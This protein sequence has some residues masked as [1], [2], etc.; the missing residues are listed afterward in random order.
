[1]LKKVI[2]IAVFFGFSGFLPVATYATETLQNSNV[3]NSAWNAVETQFLYGLAERSLS[4]QE[5]NQQWVVYSMSLGLIAASYALETR[6]PVINSLQEIE[7]VRPNPTDEP[8]CKRLYDS[9]G[10]E[11]LNKDKPNLL[12]QDKANSALQAFGNKISSLFAENMIGFTTSPERR[13]LMINFVEKSVTNVVSISSQKALIIG[14]E[15]GI[16]PACDCIGPTISPQELKFI[17]SYYPNAG[18]LA[19]ETDTPP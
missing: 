12:G 15:S 3:W 8:I 1:M 13:D 17:C 18:K 14:L 16:S 7:F 4:T 5:W 11:I 10:N 19:R 9:I 2:R 6:D